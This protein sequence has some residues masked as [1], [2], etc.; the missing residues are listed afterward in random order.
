MSA[1]RWLPSLSLFSLASLGAAGIARADVINDKVDISAGIFIVDTTTNLRVDGTTRLGTSIDLEHD[2]G[3]SSRN[4]FR[5]DGYWRFATRHKIRIEYFENTRSAGKNIDRE[6]D[7]GDTTFPIDTQLNASFKS[8]VL[9]GAY[10]Y[11]FLRSETYE[12]AGSIGLHDMY[13]KLAA[14][15]VGSTTNVSASAKANANG[16]IPVIGLHWLWQFTPEW[17]LDVLAELFG[18]KVNPYDGTLQ[19]YNVSVAWVPT[20]HWGAGI[21]WNEFIFHAGVD[22]DSFHGN[23]SWK[24]GGLRAFVKFEY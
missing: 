10:E 24:Y 9:E 14:S 1:S 17:N 23:M 22:A 11:A 13:F 7:I 6:I 18:L 8:V 21:G 19:N 20:K 15:A 2:L 3:L 4:S 12:L 16:P 5:L